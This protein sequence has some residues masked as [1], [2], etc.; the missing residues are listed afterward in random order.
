MRHLFIFLSLMFFLAAC[1][2]N[3][4]SENAVSAT[5]GECPE[6]HKI[7]GNK[8]SNGEWIYHLPN[9]QYYSR[10]NAEECFSSKLDAETA[11]YRK[12]KR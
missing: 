6:D 7:K 4:L 8:N 2:G 1:G 3:S 10:T 12:P 5:N 11:G 9:G